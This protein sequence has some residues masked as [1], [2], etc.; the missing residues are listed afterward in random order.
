MKQGRE[1]ISKFK[2]IAIEITQNKTQGK[3]MDNKWTECPLSSHGP[4]ESNIARR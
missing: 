1:K 3:K 2:T 4:T